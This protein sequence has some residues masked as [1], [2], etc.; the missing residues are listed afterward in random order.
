MLKIFHL[1]VSG[2]KADFYR[3]GEIMIS[4]FPGVKCKAIRKE[5]VAKV[6]G[7]LIFASILNVK[8]VYAFKLCNSTYYILCNHMQKMYPS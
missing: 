8:E 3:C 5:F 7:S 1:I 6:L 4:K 2:N